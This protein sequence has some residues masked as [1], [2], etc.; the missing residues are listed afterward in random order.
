MALAACGGGT[1]T[2]TATG[3]TTTRPPTSSGARPAGPP[4]GT[5]GTAAAVSATNVEVQNPTNG[6]V[7][8][9]FNAST[10]FT[11]T[12]PATLA[13]VTVGSCVTVAA[14][15][16]GTQAK[17]LTAR[18]V[19]VS[20]PASGGTCT[21]GGGGFGGAGAGAPGTTRTPNP[22]RPRPTGTNGAPANFGAAF[23]SV[24]A[25]S[26]TGFTVQG[27]ARGTT[28]AVTTVVTVNSTTTY[29]KTAAATSST[30]VVGDCV[31]A[32]G[33]A[34]DTGAVTARTINISKPGPTGC[35]AGFGG[36][37]GFRGGNGTGQ[38]N[39]TGTGTGGG[40]G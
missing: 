32:V 25:A 23:G 39:G 6:Q 14:A 21:G 40:N 19:T 35:T 11:D 24:T 20:A 15:T 22:S 1:S 10:T 34:D 5:F 3:P 17:T 37:G 38:G 29:T 18:T 7:T 13:D 30:L 9:N 36:R 31:T 12:V 2:P 26:P 16:G 4:P 33:T 28:P 27:V 8:V